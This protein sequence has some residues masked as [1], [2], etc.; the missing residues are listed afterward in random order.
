L[1]L[2]LDA[3]LSPRVARLLTASGVEAGHVRDYGL[4]HAEDDEILAF[5][6]TSDH[7]LV[8]EDTDFGEILG[9]TRAAAP[10]VVLLRTA[11]PMTP[12]EQAVLLATN[13]P[14]VA[15]ALADGSLVV[16]ARGRMRVRPLPFRGA[17]GSTSPA[18]ARRLRRAVAQHRPAVEG[19]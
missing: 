8:S 19:T 10:S 18:S 14:A 1:R 4:R 3:N 5:A 16:I 11:D 15:T 6:A 12:E 17:A 9:A 7:V 2:L 13:L